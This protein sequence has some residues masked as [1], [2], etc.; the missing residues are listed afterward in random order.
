MLHLSTP[1]SNVGESVTHLIALTTGANFP[2]IIMPAFNCRGE[3]ALFFVAY[4]LI[5]FYVLLNITLAVAYDTFSAGMAD[6]AVTKFSRVFGGFDLA[7]AELCERSKAQPEAESLLKQTFCDF[8]AVFRPDVPSDAAARLFDVFDSDGRGE[9]DRIE[10]RRLLLNFGRVKFWA[11]RGT[12]AL[13]VEEK[14]SSLSGTAAATAAV[15]DDGFDFGDVDF[16]NAPTAPPLG[17]G[18][19]ARSPVVANPLALVA[20]AAP[21]PV[22]VDD[23][24]ARVG[25]MRLLVPAAS[26]LSPPAAKVQLRRWGAPAIKLTDEGW[27]RA[28][29]PGS[30]WADW[31]SGALGFNDPPRRLPHGVAPFTLRAQAVSF[32]RG[33]FGVLCT[34]AIVLLN[35]IADFVQ[36]AVE[37]DDP[38]T[39]ELPAVR[40]MVPVQIASLSILVVFLGAKILFFGPRN[41]WREGVFFQLELVVLP[42]SVLAYILEGAGVIPHTTTSA[43]ML[44]Q[45]LRFLKLFSVLPGFDLMLQAIRDI[46]SVLS[47]YAVVVMA[48]FY[49]WAVVGVEL[50]GSG[51]LREGQ[52]PDPL[53]DTAYESNNVRLC[54]VHQN[55]WQRPNHCDNSPYPHSSGHSTLTRSL[56]LFCAF[57]GC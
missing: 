19:S 44:V 24:S 16:L 47:R 39:A 27:S 26:V 38:T 28:G 45:M 49:A 5:S 22:A 3:Y 34:D 37:D 9:I 14:P 17:A 13:A 2:S 29:G 52:E 51:L 33:P 42:L 18:L 40:A 12:A 15:L 32:I 53:D 30:G 23:R 36:I 31:L 56:G 6:E 20:S 41:C 46:L 50:F 8:F 7:F 57:F 1:Q 35:V 55:L 48:V 43:M 21:S 4:L 25:S 10:F 54:S 11:R